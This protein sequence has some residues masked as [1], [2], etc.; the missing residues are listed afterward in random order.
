[1]KTVAYLN[2]VFAN[3]FMAQR[4]GYL[5]AW[6]DS[7]GV[8]LAG[9]KLDGTLWT[10]GVSVTDVTSA[11]LKDT[12]PRG[13]LHV[14]T[15]SVNRKVAAILDDGDFESRGANVSDQIALLSAITITPS[16]NLYLFGDSLTEGAG[17]TG[18]L[19]L[20]VQLQ[21][22]YSAV[23]DNRIV[24]SFGYGSQPCASI[25]A[26]QGSSPSMVTM[27]VGASGFSEI[28]ASGAA[29]C[30]V[31]KDPL[32]YA[33]AAIGQSITGTLFSIP[34]TL[35]KAGTTGQYSFTRTTAGSLTKIPTS[36]PFI[37]DTSTYQTQTAICWIGTN[38]LLSKTAAEILAYID[39]Y[40]GF[41]S[42]VQK[43][44][45]IL[46]PIFDCDG[47]SVATAKTNY[48]TLLPLVL[49]KYPTECIDTLALLQRNG[50]GGGTDNTDVTN[51]LMPTSLTAADRIHLNNAGYGV[52]AAEIKRILDSKG[53]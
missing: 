49:D 43:R 30:T 22:L 11:V 13:Y 33:N 12:A 4:T 8:L 50:D 23:P 47:A 34:G 51:G 29:N 38:D 3:G 25:L 46:M 14:W 53:Y 40:V 27:A 2:T 21:A 36:V 31:T 1:M 15:D 19:T 28:P 17:S 37:P 52:V 39:L 42:T 44:R 16:T 45:I 9:I 5:Y 26:R 10:K 20:G 6:V 41:Q 35:A 32:L 24:T 18:G 48:A 7:A